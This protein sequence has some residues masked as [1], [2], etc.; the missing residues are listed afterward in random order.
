MIPRQSAKFFSSQVFVDCILL[1]VSNSNVFLTLY[2]YALEADAGTQGDALLTEVIG[3]GWRALT[4]VDEPIVNGCASGYRHE[5]YW[6]TVLERVQGL[7]QKKVA[8]TTNTGRVDI[9]HVEPS[10]TTTD[11]AKSSKVEN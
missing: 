11:A 7:E 4:R 6:G 5:E 1:T 2:T 8:V 3:T 10:S 9:N